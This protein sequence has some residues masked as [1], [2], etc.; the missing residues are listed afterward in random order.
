ME[1]SYGSVVVGLSKTVVIA[2][3]GVNHLKNPELA[4]R[5]VEAAT[6]A[7]VD[8]LKFQT[9]DASLLV[10][11]NAPRF[12]SWEG[13]RNSQGG[14]RDSYRYLE[15]PSLEFTKFLYSLCEENKIEFMSTP[16]DLNA[17]ETLEEVGSKGY[18]IASGDITN[19]QL[20]RAV[21]STRKPVFLSTGASS[22]SEIEVALEI[23]HS[24]GSSEICIMHCTLCYPTKFRNANLLAVS[25]LIKH[26][27]GYVIGLSDHTIGP[28][29]PALAA[30]V[31][32]RVVEKHFT[33]DKSLPDSAD[34]WLSVDET[35]MTM[36]VQNLRIAEASRG[37][38][39]KGP[40]LC[41][42]E[43]RLNARR[44]LVVKG[45]IQ[46]GEKFTH[47]NITAKRPATGISAIYYDE[48]MGLTATQDLMDDEILSPQHILEDCTFK[49]IIPQSI[50][51]REKLI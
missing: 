3:A 37:S 14:Q 34:H 41:E 36:L 35:E 5:I 31:G 21:G 28:L 16:F 25:D 8:I 22:M 11:A 9:Y 39:L 6:R 27:P 30:M 38:G 2:E 51:N 23:L 32:S 42:E 33:V 13:E 48:V 1:F 50:A 4:K 17:V 46:A 47:L 43:T 7:G 15:T 12:W 44:S 29:T 49:R 45:G 10:T 18:K 20:L 24:A 26:F 19:L 40:L